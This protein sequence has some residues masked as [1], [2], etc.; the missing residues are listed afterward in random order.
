[1]QDFP[2]N[3]QLKQVPLVADLKKEGYRMKVQI[4]RNVLENQ[5][6]CPKFS[7]MSKKDLSDFRY[8]QI[9]SLSLEAIAL[10]KNVSKSEVAIVP[11]GGEINIELTCP[12]GEVIKAQSL[13]N[14]SDNFDYKYGRSV[15]LYRALF[16]NDVLHLTHRIPSPLL[17][18]ECSS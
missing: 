13:C 8:R 12:Y 16:G 9:S 14:W 2:T 3:Q 7:K 1:M 5:K 15:A 10:L 4:F 6:F 17:F 18:E 11:R